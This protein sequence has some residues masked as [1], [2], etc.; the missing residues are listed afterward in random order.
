MNLSV[1]EI[2]VRERKKQQRTLRDVEKATRI[3]RQ[4]IEAL[5]QNNWDQFESKVYIFG[6]IKTYAKYLGIHQEKMIA[7]FRRDYEKKENVQFKKRLEANYF[8]PETRKLVLGSVIV[9]SV[10]F[11]S[12]FIYQLVLFLSPPE[13][14]I[15]SPE[16]NIIQNEERITVQ[17]QTERDA[18]IIIQ[19]DRVFQDEEGIFTYDLPL[20]P[21]RNILEIEVTG[22]NGKKTVKTTEFILED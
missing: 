14:A 1:G 11:F 9:L 17:A 15:I 19:G 21:G 20:K 22:A 13:V 18:E 5:E 6:L 16:V 12:Y 10:L 3:R 7:Y 4:Y 8:R 2:L